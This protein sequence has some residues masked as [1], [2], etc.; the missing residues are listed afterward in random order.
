[1]TMRYPIPALLLWTVLAFAATA[2]F[3]EPETQE[4]SLPPF[5]V[6]KV[7]IPN[8]GNFGS[9][10]ASLS[11][12]LPDSAQV[13]QEVYQTKNGKSLGD[14]LQSITLQG[15]TT[16]MVVNNSG[17]LVAMQ[18]GDYSHLQT[19]EGLNSPRYLHIYQDS[20]GFVTDL[21]ADAIQ[22]LLLQTGER[23][24][25][26]R[27]E[28]WTEEWHLVGE[29]LWTFVP[30]SNQLL[31]IDR[32]EKTLAKEV[33]VGDTIVDVEHSASALYV[34][35]R[36]K[37]YRYDAFG[38][39][40]NEWPFP[41]GS[42]PSDL[43]LDKE[44]GLLYALDPQKSD[45]VALYTLNLNGEQWDEQAPNYAVEQLYAVGLHPVT[46]H[47][48]LSDAKDYVRKGEVH[49]IDPRGDSLVHS[50]STGIIPG[51]AVF[52]PQD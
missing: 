31:Q 11:V 18:T 37:L 26:I 20:L 42:A 35:G 5:S 38:A 40:Q 47:L 2:C 3:Q 9:G 43:V 13:Y 25:A 7:L 51:K 28:G 46:G 14:V 34:L 16:W 22:S 49:I 23:K 44:R 19:I 8:E 6:D 45:S 41:Q 36:E 33:L 48:Y 21:Y 4:N 30:F 50:F 24:Q 1:M 15:D 52:V 12:Y 29:K 39:F 17:R 27:I 10:N 32:A